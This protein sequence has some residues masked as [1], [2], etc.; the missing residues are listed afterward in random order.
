MSN[1]QSAVLGILQ[2]VGEF[3]PVSSSAHLAIAPYF[4]GWKYQG[5]AY[6][7]MLHLG[8]LCAILI[9][10]AKDWVKIIHDGV[11]KPR[12]NDGK[13]LWLVVL[14]TIPGALAGYFLEDL[15]ET[16][17]RNPAWIGLNLIFFSIFIYLA[18]RNPEQSLEISS[19]NV[20]DA[21]IIGI[22]QALAI[23]PGASRAGM[24]IMAGLFLGYKRQDSARFSFLLATPIIF[25]AGILEMRKFTASAMDASLVLGFLFSFI[26]G[27]LSIKFLLSYLKTK[28]LIIF[29]VY[30][31][32]LGGLILYKFKFL[33]EKF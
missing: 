14:A 6:D 5:L 16:V 23:F 2:G 18:D 27:W 9:Y 11:K 19:I 3:L 22:A 13:I 8:T 30:R 1:F 29:I 4:F 21:L 25:G 20:K 17:F 10:F 24:T 33:Q 28:N 32:L 7:V 26:S 12:E 15:A 31:I